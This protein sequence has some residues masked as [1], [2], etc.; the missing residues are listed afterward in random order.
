MPGNLSAILVRTRRRFLEN[1]GYEQVRVHFGAGASR[2]SGAPLMG[3]FLE[4]AALLL[5]SESAV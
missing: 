3:D 1:R 5:V 4:K 2:N